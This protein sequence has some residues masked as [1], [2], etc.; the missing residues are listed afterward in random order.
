MGV[1]SVE[2]LKRALKAAHARGDLT[3]ARVLKAELDRVG[4][5]PKEKAE[6]PTRFEL[7]IEAS[8]EVR[9]AAGNLVDGDRKFTATAV[10]TED[11]LRRQLEERAP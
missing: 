1:H 5:P 4:S 2:A 7:V 8:G 9:D 10:L 3:R 6:Q 11:E